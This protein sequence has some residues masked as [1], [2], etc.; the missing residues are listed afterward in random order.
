MKLQPLKMRLEEYIKK[1]QDSRW[2]KIVRDI[3]PHL[4]EDVERCRRQFFAGKCE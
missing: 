1:K 3:A 4:V 2:I